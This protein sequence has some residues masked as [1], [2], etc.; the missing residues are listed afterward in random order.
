MTENH[1]WSHAN[2]I[3][4]EIFRFNHAAIFGKIRNSMTVYIRFKHKFK[5]SFIF[6]FDINTSSISLYAVKWKSLT[7]LSRNIFFS[8]FFGS[9]ENGRNIRTWGISRPSMTLSR[10]IVEYEWPYENETFSSNKCNSKTWF[11]WLHFVQFCSLLS[12]FLIFPIHFKTSKTYAER[13]FDC[14]MEVFV[15]ECFYIKRRKV[16]FSLC[17]L[18]CISLRFQFSFSVVLNVRHFWNECHRSISFP[19]V[20]SMPWEKHP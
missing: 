18:L 15:C 3:F 14:K 9:N 2:L 8:F 13:G 19:F 17:L 6:H 10:Y 11:W 4:I 20:Y 12:D 5:F 7:Q 16:C 1:F